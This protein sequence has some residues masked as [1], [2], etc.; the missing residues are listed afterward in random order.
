MN[1]AIPLAILLVSSCAS[2]ADA[3]IFTADQ[4]IAF[5]KKVCA[6][7]SSTDWKAQ[8][9]A[10]LSGFGRP[11]KGKGWFV[12]GTLLHPSPHI[13]RLPVLV[14]VPKDGAPSECNPIID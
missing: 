6:K 13:P 4:A 7:P 8:E 5:A 14:V 3:T 11:Q 10:D 12:F 9:F 2:G 1:L